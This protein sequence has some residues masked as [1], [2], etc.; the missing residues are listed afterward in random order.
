MTFEECVVDHDHD[1]KKNRGLLHK[2]CN[3]VLHRGLGPLFFRN[4]ADYL[5]RQGIGD[6]GKPKYQMI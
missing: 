5:T 4:L 6:D 2:K 1:T 3:H